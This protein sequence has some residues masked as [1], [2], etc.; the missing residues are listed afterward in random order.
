MCTWKISPLCRLGMPTANVVGLGHGAAVVQV[1]PPRLVAGK[2]GDLPPVYNP[3][4]LLP[5]PSLLKRSNFT[6]TL[7]PSPAYPKPP[8]ADPMAVR[9][10][11]WRTKVK[12]SPFGFVN[13]NVKSLVNDCTLTGVAQKALP[14]WEVGAVEVSC[15]AVP[16]ST[17]LPLNC[18]PA[19]EKPEPKLMGVF[20]AA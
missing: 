6:A 9:P 11:F 13:W 8:P 12:P 5:S 10:V 2:L 16:L 19:A 3:V 4:E 14:T 7:L 18:I 17:A 20:A 15:R 1:P